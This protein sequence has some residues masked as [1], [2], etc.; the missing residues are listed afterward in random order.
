[1]NLF[2]LVSQA[3]QGQA[4]A[5]IGAR[6]G[7]DPTQAE[8]AVRAL[9]PA[10]S[11]GLKHNSASEGGLR[12]LIAALGSGRHV[13]YAEGPDALTRPDVTQEGNGILGHILGSKEVSRKVAAHAEANTG[14]SAAILRKMLPLLAPVV[15]GA[16]AKQVL[17]SR[18][19]RN[20][21]KVLGGGLLARLF[22]SRLL[23][24]IGVGFLGKILLNGLKAGAW[25]VL[26]RFLRGRGFA[27]AR[28]G[29]DFFGSLLDAD[30]D[31]QILDDLLR[32]ATSRR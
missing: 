22:G 26:R 9:L 8:A 5:N 24:L 14:I 2:D 32:M 17:G 23:R 31:G 3:Q 27:S 7:L 20:I 16:L 19:G 29:S 28:S 4:I 11:A 30:G 1:M 10:L 25:A 18:L 21:G 13:D 6:V 15:M 12:S